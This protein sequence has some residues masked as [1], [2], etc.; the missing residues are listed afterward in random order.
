MSA[1][2]HLACVPV[3]LVAAGCGTE[4]KEFSPDGKFKVLLPGTPKEQNQSAMGLTVKAWSAEEK[5]GAYII[6]AT[7]L[8]AAL[9]G[10]G[11]AQLEQQLDGARSGALANSGAKLTSEKKITLAGKYPGRHIEAD[12]PA[13]NGKMKMR[14][15]IVGNRLY[16]MIAVGNGSWADSADATKFLDSLELVGE[17]APSKQ[18][19]AK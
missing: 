6:S 10:Q 15:Y 14:V 7:D 16:S 5:N 18:E 1:G 19:A 4:F 3:C 8:P 12:V 2:V 17:P 9:V 13:K 11:A